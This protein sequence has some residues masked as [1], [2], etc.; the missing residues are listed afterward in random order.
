MKTLRI[1]I[2]F[3]VMMTILMG[4]IYPLVV[5]TIAQA[6]FLQRANGSIVVDAAGTPRGSALV[7]QSFDDSRYFWGRLSA[8]GYNGAS[9]GG[10]N[11][12]I[13]NPKLLEATSARMTALKQADPAQTAEPPVDLVTASASGLDPHISLAAAD[14]Q[15]GRVATA[16]NMA[17]DTVQGYI[18]AHTQQPF[19]G[20]IGQPVVNVLTLN[21]ALDAHE[22][23]K[24]R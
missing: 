13:N 24:S 15:A 14:Y 6:A 5:T 23:A 17:I 21:M 12:G 18:N 1:S 2:I 8:V 11:Y 7:G 19:L 9:S 3:F 16:R 22:P 20:I 10:S 4:G